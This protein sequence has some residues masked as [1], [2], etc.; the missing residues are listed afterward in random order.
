MNAF[1]EEMDFLQRR[2]DLINQQ[3]V[4]TPEEFEANQKLQTQLKKRK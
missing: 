2:I 3:D 4:L 1:Q